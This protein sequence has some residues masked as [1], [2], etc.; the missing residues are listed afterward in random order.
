MTLK[1]SANVAR[2][3][4]VLPVAMNEALTKRMFACSKSSLMMS[5]GLS[6]VLLLCHS[7][8]SLCLSTRIIY[9]DALAAD[10]HDRSTNSTVNYAS[11]STSLSSPAISPFSGT[12]CIAAST[13]NTHGDIAINTT[14]PVKLTD[15]PQIS[16]YVK[17]SAV[18]TLLVLGF[19]ITSSPNDV[20]LLSPAVPMLYLLSPF[21][22]SPQPN[23]WYSFNAT[24]TNLIANYGNTAKL[25]L[26]T[27]SIQTFQFQIQTTVTGIVFALDQIVLLPNA[28]TTSTSPPVTTTSPPV[29]TSSSAAAAAAASTTSVT[30]SSASTL[31]TSTPSTSASPSSSS[32]AATNLNTNNNNNSTTSNMVMIIGIIAGVVVGVVLIGVILFKVRKEMRRVQANELAIR[33]VNKM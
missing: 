6:L 31:T 25:D 32:S 9:D 23:T 12:A 11:S 18:S 24:F 27:L 29:T 15:Y 5:V 8:L 20:P 17:V 26:T 10:F 30:T 33:A 28:T 2:T 22:S 4:V 7:P 21:V 16:G 13:T 14:N 1:V 3:K 19:Q